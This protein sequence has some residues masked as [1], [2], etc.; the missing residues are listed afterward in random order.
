MILSLFMK[1]II[2]YVTLDELKKR[3]EEKQKKLNEKYEIVEQSNEKLVYKRSIDKYCPN[4]FKVKINGEEDKVV[5]Y[6]LEDDDIITVYK[7]IEVYKDTLR[8]ELVDE[9]KQGIAVDSKKELN[10]LIEDI[11]S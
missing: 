2:Q 5:I 8:E 6:S 11:E 7:E 4:H 10:L 3:E 9:L 1:I